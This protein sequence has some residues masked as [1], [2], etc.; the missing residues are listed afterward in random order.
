MEKVIMYEQNILGAVATLRQRGIA[1]QGLRKIALAVGI[2]GPILLAP[3]VGLAAKHHDKAALHGHRP[4]A[5]HLV[6][7]GESK[8]P[9][10]FNG[11]KTPIRAVMA[12]VFRRSGQ[13]YVFGPHVRGVVTA[14]L[15]HIPFDT[16]VEALVKA[17]SV[18]L[19]MVIKNGVYIIN[20]RDQPR[21]EPRRTRSRTATTTNRP[22]TTYPQ[23]R[24]TT[25]P[26]NR[27]AY[28]P[29][30]RGYRSVGVG[31]SVRI[32]P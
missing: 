3:T 10:T 20:A 15:N 27:R 5:I 9:V 22:T 19:T 26:T 7:R 23:R 21:I 31:G 32:A 11:V 1:K 17:N 18:P 4:V 8:R 6:P 12:L 16:A 25:Y 30:R 2:L 24:R 28:I 14:S 13:N 29:N